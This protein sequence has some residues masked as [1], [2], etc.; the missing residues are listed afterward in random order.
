MLEKANLGLLWIADD[1]RDFYLQMHIGIRWQEGASVGRG[2]G[3]LFYED[4]T[5]T[6]N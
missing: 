4:W 5:E 1:F 2:T 6:F 3:A